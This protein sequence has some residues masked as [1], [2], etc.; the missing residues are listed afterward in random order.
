M[1][2]VGASA[3][4][5]DF[6]GGTRRASVIL[7]SRC[8][9]SFRTTPSSIS[10]ASGASASR[11]RRCC[12]SSPSRSTS[13][14]GLNFGIDFIGGTLIEVQSKAGPADLAKMRDDARRTGAGRRAVAAIRRS[15]RRAHP[16]RAAARRRRGATGRHRQGQGSAGQ[17]T[18]D[19]RRVEVVGTA[20]VDRAAGLQ[21]DRSRCSRSSRS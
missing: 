1:G 11:S 10:C 2:E 15:D 12:R 3:A 13:F 6:I 4:I 19:Y 7:P 21:H 5:G 16:R 14:H 8:C 18:L 20:G 17:T 9:G